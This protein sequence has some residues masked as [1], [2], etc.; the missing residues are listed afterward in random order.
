M[1]EEEEVK[2]ACS[3]NDNG[4]PSGE[5]VDP[6]IRRIAEAIGDSLLAR[7]VS[8]QPRP[9][10]MPPVLRQFNPAVLRQGVHR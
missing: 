3:A 10:T 5:P 6:R 4:S 8:L 9:T 1:A 2:G 7:R